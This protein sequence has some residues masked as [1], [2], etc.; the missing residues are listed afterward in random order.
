M[1]AHLFHST[2]HADFL[3]LQLLQLA[4]ILL[5][6]GFSIA[7]TDLVCCPQLGF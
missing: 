3:E 5:G 1:L 4:D 2:L 7:C 6:P